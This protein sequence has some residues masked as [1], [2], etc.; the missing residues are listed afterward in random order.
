LKSGQLA[1]AP[2][3]W[4]TPPIS[5]PPPGA[6]MEDSPPAEQLGPSAAPP[7]AEAGSRPPL[8]ELGPVSGP[9]AAAD[10]AGGPPVD[11]R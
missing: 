7:D 9:P 11:R 2:T 10:E 4:P 8:E 6:D 3:P 5:E 1:E